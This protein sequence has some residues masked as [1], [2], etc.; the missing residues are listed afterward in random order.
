VDFNNVPAGSGLPPLPVPRRAPELKPQRFILAVVIHVISKS[1]TRHISQRDLQAIL[2]RSG[3]SPV[4]NH[5]FELRQRGFLARNT[6]RKNLT[7]ADVY[8]PGRLLSNTH[9]DSWTELSRQLF[10]KKGLCKKLLNRPAFGTGFLNTNGMLIIGTLLRS[11]RPLKVREIH[12][13][14]NFFI[15]DEGTIRNRLKLAQKHGLV[16]KHGVTWTTT[17]A[18][19]EQLTEYELTYGPTS[20]QERVARRTSAERIKFAIHLRKGKLTPREE[21]ELRDQGCIRCG[22]T[23]AQHKRRTRTNLQM[24]HFPPR[25][26]LKTWGYTDKYDFNWAICIK[27]NNRYSPYIKRTD[28]PKLPKFIRTAFTEKANKD[29]VVVAALETAILRFY[30]HIDAGDDEKATAIALNAFI[31]WAGIVGGSI[32]VANTTIPPHPEATSTSRRLTRR[33]N[34]VSPTGG[35]VRKSIST[36]APTRT[37]GRKSR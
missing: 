21:K 31:L 10:D 18:F 29:T 20:R 34:K 4:Q 2:N 32:P 25:K 12:E 1:S 17:T 22:A 3:R 14:L 6:R 19:W 27:C 23:N 36:S 33:T 30:R 24:E 16:E 8:R 28:V 5:L 35:S 11:S 9:F 37:R 26:W 7:D 13:Y 15:S